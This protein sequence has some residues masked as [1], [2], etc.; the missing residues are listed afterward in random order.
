MDRNPLVREPVR[1]VFNYDMTELPDNVTAMFMATWDD[2][3]GWT[4]LTP[5]SGFISEEGLI[6]GL[7]YH[8]STFS[9]IAQV[10]SD[11]P[12]TTPPVITLPPVL[13]PARFEI[14]DLT[15]S[16][17]QVDSGEP[18]TVRVHVANTGEI[19]GEHLITL[20]INDMFIESKLVTLAPGK[21]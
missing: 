12:V 20:T 21:S 11:E 3:L 6:G 10:E 2:E 15:I 4:Q 18:V 1:L 5:I 7:A 14:Y 16:E 19:S 8:F 13:L 9:I 17:K